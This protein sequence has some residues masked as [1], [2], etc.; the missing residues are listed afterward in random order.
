MSNI[1]IAYVGGKYNPE[2]FIAEAKRCGSTRRVSRQEVQGMAFG[3]QVIFCYLPKKGEDRTPYAFATMRIASIVLGGPLGELVTNALEAA[4]MAERVD[5]EPIFVGRACGE[6]LLTGGA[7]VT[8]ELEYVAQTAR[9]I[10]EETGL[11]EWYMVG[12]HPIAFEEHQPVTAAWATA[13]VR[14]FTL[15]PEVQAAE[16][17]VDPHVLLVTDYQQS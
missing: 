17:P 4:G 13:K 2:K 1:F 6:Y 16:W 3:D 10:A 7:S 5:S 9:Q 8:C 14:G 11:E 15:C 12:G